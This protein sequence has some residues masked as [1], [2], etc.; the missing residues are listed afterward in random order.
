MRQRVRSLPSEVWKF[1]LIHPEFIIGGVLP[2]ASYGFYCAAVFK[3]VH[4][5]SPGTNASAD[6]QHLTPLITL[7]LSV[8]G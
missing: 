3:G 6:D 7:V 4:Q 5:Q 1:F 2:I 8:V